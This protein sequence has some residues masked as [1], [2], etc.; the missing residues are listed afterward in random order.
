MKTVTSYFK[1]LMLLFALALAN[2]SLA[3]CTAVINQVQNGNGN[4]TFSAI[5]TGTNGTTSYYWAFGDGGTG[6]GN[7]AIHTY[8]SN[9][10]TLATLTVVTTAPAC[11]VVVMDTV[12][13]STVSTPC[14]LASGF[15]Y[16]LGANGQVWFY[17][18]STGTNGNS[19]YNWNFGDASGSSGSLSSHIYANPGTYVVSLTVS[20]GGTCTSTYTQSINVIS[21]CTAYAGYVLSPDTIVPQLWYVYPNVPNNVIAATWSWGDGSYSNTLYTSH[22]YSVAGNYIICLSIVVACGDSATYC[23]TQ[24][25]YRSKAASMVQVNVVSGS[26]VG[27]KRAAAMDFGYTI[28]PNPGNGLF[29]LHLNGLQTASAKIEVLSITGKKV[30]VSDTEASGSS[31]KKEIDLSYLPQGVYF[32]TVVADGKAVAKKIVIDK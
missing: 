28:A 17:N 16:S 1:T 15:T 20:N 10:L 32:M 7:P 14:N 13:I 2:T 4:F 21:T 12:V 22:Q 6:S 3:Q 30:Y 9:G 5:A 27:L 18:N 19:T 8:T 23:D 24:Y 11:T 31:F 25:V 26:P 29:E